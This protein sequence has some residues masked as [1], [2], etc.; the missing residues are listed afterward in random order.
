MPIKIKGEI[1]STCPK[2]GCWMRVRAEEDTILV[3]SKITVFLFLNKESRE[4]KL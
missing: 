4:K 3:D 2:K 1:L